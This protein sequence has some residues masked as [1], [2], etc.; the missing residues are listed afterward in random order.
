MNSFAEKI[1][2]KTAIQDFPPYFIKNNDGTMGGMAI[3]LMNLIEK[4]SNYKFVY[5]TTFTPGPRIENDIIEG[6]ND[7]HVGFG[8]TPER[9]K[10]LVYTDEVCNVT[11]I[12][13]TNIDE[14]LNPKTLADIKALNK[15]GTVLCMFGSSISR[16]LKEKYGLIVD[17]GAK[18]LDDNLEKLLD[19]RAHFLI[20]SDLSLAYFLKQPRYKGKFKVLDI[21]VEKRT[22]WVIFS[23]KTPQ[24]VVKGVSVAI[25]KAKASGE[26][27]KIISKYLKL[28]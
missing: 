21:K 6:K 13:L 28:E 5:D 25:K 4:Y 14:T 24:S 16:S 11:T 23:K 17:D 22:Q 1:T 19:K 2:V 20:Y 26:W 15:D 8:K 12:V 18:T 3:E 27:D 7:I 10:N 9:E